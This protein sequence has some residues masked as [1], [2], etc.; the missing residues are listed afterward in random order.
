MSIKIESM[1]GRNHP[2]HPWQRR[3][4]RAGILGNPFGMR[5]LQDRDSSCDKYHTWFYEQV[6]KGNAEIMEEL[7]NLL[8]IHKTF[9]QVT[10]M[11]W[12]APLRCHSETIKEYL[13]SFIS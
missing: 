9:G 11:C 5:N 1:R 3:V 4:D 8:H 12:C 13:E 7:A 10:L 6:D 2:V